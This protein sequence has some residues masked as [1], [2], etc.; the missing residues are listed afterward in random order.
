MS[1]NRPSKF[2][3]PN[4]APQINFF[5]QLQK[6]KGE[7]LFEALA[8]TV[9]TINIKTLDNE[10]SEEVPQ[11]RLQTVRSY[12]LPSE[13]V[14]VAPYLLSAN[15]RLV[16]YYRLLIGH[17][18]K[19]FYSQGAF[20]VFAT[21]EEKGRISKEQSHLLR[22]LCDSLNEATWQLISGIS[23]KLTAEN[24]RELTLL[25]LGPQLRGG[26][27]VEIGADATEELFQT[28]QRTLT[29]YTPSVKDKTIRLTNAKGNEIVIEFGSDPDIKI[30]EM[31]GF[32]ERQNLSWPT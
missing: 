30:F 16:G 27:N 14:F 1:S 20:G 28:F 19:Q 8:A 6:L 15:P 10:L 18:K 21:M 13:M 5:T 17:S 3:V 9:K 12:G 32:G 2:T 22:D 26:H 23:Q 11:E 29:P 24:I 25:T 31:T 4:P 7:I